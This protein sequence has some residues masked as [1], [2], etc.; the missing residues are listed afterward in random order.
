M[1]YTLRF[2]SLLVIALMMA[3]SITM[4]SSIKPLAAWF[5]AFGIF[6]P[7]HYMIYEFRIYPYYVSPLR[8]L[9]TVHGFLLWGQTLTVITA[10]V[11]VPQRHWYKH[12]SPIIRYYLLFGNRRVSIIDDEA[13]KQITIKYPHVWWK[14]PPYKRLFSF[15]QVKNLND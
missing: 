2:S 11:G 7:S 12:Y 3:L 4:L 13:L 10:E 9:P 6:V 5:Y 14:A 8:F 1:A 15:C